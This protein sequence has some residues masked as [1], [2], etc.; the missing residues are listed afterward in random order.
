M[1][2]LKTI[3]SR[4]HLPQCGRQSDR[5]MP[6]ISC[7]QKGLMKEKLTGMECG[8]QLFMLYLASLPSTVKQKIIILEQQ[9]GNRY[10][11]FDVNLVLLLW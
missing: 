9:S 2:H 10:S 1:I 4:N 5:D 11:R 6:N 3:D 8:Q 7:F